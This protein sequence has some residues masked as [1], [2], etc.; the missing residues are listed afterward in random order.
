M[1]QSPSLLVD[2]PSL[3]SNFRMSVSTTMEETVFRNVYLRANSQSFTFTDVWHVVMNSLGSL[4]L[5][6]STEIRRRAGNYAF[7]RVRWS[8]TNAYCIW[9]TRRFW[10]IM[11]AHPPKSL[12]GKRNSRLHVYLIICLY[13][14]LCAAVWGCGRVEICLPDQ[15]YRSRKR[16]RRTVGM[17]WT[18]NIQ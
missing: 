7:G 14:Q 16:T 2:R 10:S 6:L 18:C 9:L 5:T 4:H 8:A 17:L 12:P 13:D 3:Q 15:L 11:R 1:T